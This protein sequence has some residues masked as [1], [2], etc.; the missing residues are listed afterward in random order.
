M[1]TIVINEK[2]RGAKKLIEF[3]KT[4]PFVT[5]VEETKPNRLAKSINEVKSD[6]SPYNEAFVKTIQKSR[7][8]KGKVIKTEDL[9]K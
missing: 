6:E 3:L 7:A 2:S 5:I 4:Q 8:S 9:W 1:T